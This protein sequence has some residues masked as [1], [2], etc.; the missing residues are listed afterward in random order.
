MVFI[1]SAEVA[2]LVE[3][4]LAKVG[5]AGSSPVFR[6]ESPSS[7]G[8]GIFFEPDCIATSIIV[9]SHSFTFGNAT[10]QYEKFLYSCPGGGSDSYRNGRH[11]P[12]TIGMTHNGRIGSQ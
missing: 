1:I 2:H 9:A 7:F 6:S 8:G 10:Q 3:H 5:V 12:I 4:D 11:V